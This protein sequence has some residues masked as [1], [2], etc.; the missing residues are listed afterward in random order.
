M[1]YKNTK[2]LENKRSCERFIIQMTEEVKKCA[3]FSR[4]NIKTYS[5]LKQISF[6]IKNKT[7]LVKDKNQNRF[8]NNLL[9]KTFEK[10]FLKF[11]KHKFKFFLRMKMTEKQENVWNNT[12]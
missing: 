4:G 11:C 9:N 1:S 3:Q 2:R 5:K 7:I 6:P 8:P 10:N 12:N